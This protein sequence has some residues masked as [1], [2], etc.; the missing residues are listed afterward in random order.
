MKI[1]PTVLAYNK[2]EFTKLF[3]KILPTSDEIQI[4]FMDGRFVPT[5]SIREEEVPP[6]RN[7]KGKVFEAHLMVKEPMRWVP[8]LIDKGFKRIIMH[9]ETLDPEDFPVIKKFIKK[10]GAEFILAVNPETEV[11]E[12]IPLVEHIDGVL[13]LGVHPGKN[14]AEYLEETAERIRAFLKA[15]P[16]KI[17]VQVDGGMSTETIKNVVDAGATRINSG[18]FV[19]NATDP[20]KA[21]EELYKAARGGSMNSKELAKIANEARK[22]VITTL[23]QAHSGHTAGPLGMADVFTVLYYDWAKVEPQNPNWSERDYIFLSNG[24]ICA[25]WYVTLANKG[26]F[27]KEEL[28]RFRKIDSLLQGHPHSTTIPGVENSGGPLAQGLSQ[29]VGAAL[30]LKRDGLSNRVFCL[31]S[32][33]EH[34]EGQA[35]EAAMFAGKYK[36]GNLVFIMDRNHIQIDGTTEDVM[37]LEPLRDKFRAFNWNVID[38][39]GHNISEIQ[40]ALKL[41]DKEQHKPTMIIAQT[42]PGKGVSFMEGKYEWHGKPPNEEEAKKAIAELDAASKKIERRWF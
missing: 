42:T 40:K 29:A 39:D 22:Q 21:L 27:P 36:L 11:E 19:S 24:H 20:A 12:I 7:Y 10:E 2:K 13:F 37:P 17:T 18:H 4:D 34:E 32:D 1:I 3:K 8:Y 35:W 16:K 41:A 30:A 31:C 15:V 25:I 9:Y 6:V 33:G 26:F 28:E 38:I 14:G 23:Q 5:E